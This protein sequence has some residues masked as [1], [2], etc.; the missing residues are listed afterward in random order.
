MEQ[1]IIQ[2]L[3]HSCMKVTA[4]GYEIVLDP[5]ENGSVP[6]LKNLDV[7]ADEVYC[8]HDHHDHNARSVIKLKSDQEGVLKQSPFH[9]ELLPSY[10]DDA[11]GTLRGK[12]NITILSIGDLRVA[13]MGDM[14]CWPTKEQEEQLK[15]VDAMM[16]PVGGH[17]T[18]EPEECR[19][20]LDAVKPRVI[21]PMHYRSDDFGFDVIATL[22]RFLLPE[23][24]PV[25]CKEDKIALT[26]ESPSGIIVLSYCS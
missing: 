14:G 16:I 13:H 25:F 10:H 17:F 23:D 2:W 11:D 15:N 3:G 4:E 26:K 6:G 5:Y 24:Q 7:E 1:M 9:I 12:N 22:D 21:L 8:S 18:M 20:F 19:K